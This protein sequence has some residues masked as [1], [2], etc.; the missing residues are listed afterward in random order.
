ML[1]EFEHAQAE[2][3]S[4]LRQDLLYQLVSLSK[5]LP[6]PASGHT[7]QR[8]QLFAQIAG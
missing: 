8:W 2:N 6:Y 5:S 1:N 7:Y 3:K 4:Q